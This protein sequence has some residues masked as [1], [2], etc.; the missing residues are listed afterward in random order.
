M[1]LKVAKLYTYW[2]AEEVDTVNDFLDTLRDAFLVH[3]S[4][5]IIE[6]RTRA[7]RETGRNQTELDFDDDIEF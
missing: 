5:S 7:L 4:E 2:N 6:M 3:Y 1:T